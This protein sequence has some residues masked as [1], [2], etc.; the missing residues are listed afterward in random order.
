M[1]LVKHRFVTEATPVIGEKVAKR[2]E[3]DL[4]G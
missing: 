4:L 3:R 1:E 2:A